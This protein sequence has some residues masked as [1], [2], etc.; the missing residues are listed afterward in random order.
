MCVTRFHDSNCMPTRSNNFCVRD[1][2]E[3]GGGRRRGRRRPVSGGGGER[4]GRR[5]ELEGILKNSFGMNGLPISC[6]REGR[7][8]ID[9]AF[10][11]TARFSITRTIHVS[12]GMKRER[13]IRLEH[14]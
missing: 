6:P 12:V 3:E 9:S 4:G 5:G 11:V 10:E 14:E 13:K 2:E 1:D 7:E 8:G